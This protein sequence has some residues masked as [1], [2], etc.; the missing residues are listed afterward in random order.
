MIGFTA[1]ASILA[2]KPRASVA[3]PTAP[4]L[5]GEV[6]TAVPAPRMVRFGFGSHLTAQTT[7]VTSKTHPATD[8]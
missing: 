4:T 7:V 3:E 8:K 5:N 2:S 1:R 6:A